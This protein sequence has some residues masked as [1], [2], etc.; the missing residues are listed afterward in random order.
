MINA[1]PILGWLLSFFF[2][3][4][5][6]VPFYFLWNWLAPIYFYWLPDVYHSLPFWH[7]VGLFMLM[8]MVK[9][10]AFP[11]LADSSSKAEVEKT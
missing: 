6:S 2:S 7:C 5:V 9:A 8:P 3:V 4:S 11:K 10:L 1:I